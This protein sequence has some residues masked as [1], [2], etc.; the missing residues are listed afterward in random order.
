VTVDRKLN[1][2]DFIKRSAGTG[3]ALLG[4]KALWPSAGH[5]LSL[6]GVADPPDIAVVQGPNYGAG[7][8]KAVDLLGGM[9]RFVAKDARV[10]ILPNAQSNHPGTFTKPDIV[11]A[12]V[13]MCREAGAREVNCLSW[14]PAK[15]WTAAGLDVALRDEGAA[16]KIVDLRDASLF[17]PVPLPKGKILT[18]ARIM[19]ELFAHDCLINLPITKDHAG[20]KFTGAMKNMMA[21][22]FADVNRTF[23]TG[24]FKTRP[25]DID[26]LDQCI[27]DLN[28]VDSYCASLRNLRA[29]DILMIRKGHEHGLGEM[30][31]KNVKIREV[32]ES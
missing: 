16:L 31:L 13:R 6:A 28:L 3:A 29:E 17:K 10:A 19:S 11:R 26:R 18:E 15:F 14:L 24:D 20:N 8:R 23:H 4:A 30:D 7:A 21:L 9:R 22:N 1:R 5:G 32:A 12:V 25:D 2:R 27:A